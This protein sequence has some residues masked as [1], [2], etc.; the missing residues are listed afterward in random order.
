METLEGTLA[1]RVEALIQLHHPAD[2]TWGSPHA[3]TTPLS[4]AVHNLAAEVAALE[5]AVREIA[6]EVERLSLER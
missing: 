6:L 1:E 4:L 2:A 5:N 3:A